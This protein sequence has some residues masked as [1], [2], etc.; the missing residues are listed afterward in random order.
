MQVA[1]A[2]AEMLVR[3]GDI[4]R[5]EF[6]AI[7]R[8]DVIAPVLGGWAL[9]AVYSD[10][11]LR[12]I[13]DHHGDPRSYVSYVSIAPYFNS[14]DATTAT[15]GGLFTGLDQVI[16][17]MDPTLR[18]FR[19]LVDE[20]GVRIAGYEGGQGYTGTTNQQIKHLAQHDSRMHDAYL[21]FF[22]A[23]KQHFG[24]ALF[25]HFSL[26]GAQVP[27]NIYQY[28][29]W[30]SLTSVLEDPGQCTVGAHTLTG[31]ETIASVEGFCPKYQAL[32]E[33]VPR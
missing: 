26:A 15:L 12:F 22:A 4:F 30:G 27:E 21:A 5:T 20:W 24:E 13:R 33:Q 28:G 18:S 32:L 10:Q 19:Q 29:Y 16:Q 8:R 1:Q 14:P 25:L 7:G 3:T 9:G 2:H 11:G 31:D 23:W 6:D 17:G